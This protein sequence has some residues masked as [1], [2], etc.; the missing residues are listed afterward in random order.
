[1]ELKSETTNNSNLIS[2]FSEELNTFL[3]NHIDGETFTIDRIENNVAI[4][5]NRNTKKFINIHI[6]KLPENIKENDII[7]YMNGQYILDNQET[8]DAKEN[9]KSK[10]DKLRKK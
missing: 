2:D 6:S 8:L 9:I 10:F 3:E 4:C 5:E 1:M 7:K